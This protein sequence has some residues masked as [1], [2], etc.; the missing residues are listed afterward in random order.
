MM[1]SPLVIKASGLAAGKGV[2][3]ATSVREAEEVL[4]RMMV[5]RV[6]E[7]AADEVVLESFLDGREVSLLAFVDEKTAIPMPMACDYKRLE[8]GNRGP[9]TGGMGAYSSPPWL[10]DTLRATIMDRIFWPTIEALRS[11]SL[12]YRGVL[13]FGLMITEEG[14]W[15]LEFNVRFG[16]PETQVVIPRLE[17]DLLDTLAAVARG[18]LTG[19]RLREGP[20]AAVTI[21]L[22]G[23]D[24]PAR[25]DYVGVEIEG[26]EDAEAAGALVF[27][28]GTAVREGT[29]VTNGGRILSLTALG[30]TLR[31]ARERAYAAVERVSFEGMRYR[32]DIASVPVG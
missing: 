21:V 13:Y 19:S 18:D 16:D 30:P 9:N 26:L 6:F 4:R 3:V 23:P 25:S 8:D 7:G 14:P 20:D 22:A 32:T 28:G 24:Y 31:E 10:D 15:V 5:D 11:E 12:N 17:G 29:L 1:P 2:T 27:Q